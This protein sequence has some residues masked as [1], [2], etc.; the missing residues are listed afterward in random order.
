MKFFI[1]SLVLFMTSITSAIENGTL[2]Y[3]LYVDNSS[4][5][6]SSPQIEM[7]IKN[8]IDKNIIS[9][10]AR[11]YDEEAPLRIVVFAAIMDVKNLAGEITGTIFSSHTSIRTY[12][13][14][15]DALTPEKLGLGITGDKYD[16]EFIKSYFDREISTIFG[17]FDRMRDLLNNVK[18]NE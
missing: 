17:E 6:Y 15:Y 8:C 11:T 10:L 16:T 14:A 7:I 1:C 3:K 4:E 12:P 5:Y 2:Y 13:S 9:G 18:T